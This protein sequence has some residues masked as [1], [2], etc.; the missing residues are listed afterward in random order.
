MKMK[1]VKCSDVGISNCDY[2]ALGNDLGEVEQ[3]MLD[4]IENE[5]KSLLESMT[6]DEAHL[7]KH[8]VSTFLGR[9]CGCGRVHV[10]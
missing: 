2:I 8:R 5:H 6:G 3:N 7:L 9:S 1:I 4:H 10:L